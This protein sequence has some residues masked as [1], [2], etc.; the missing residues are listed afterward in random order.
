MIY[1]GWKGKS[2]RERNEPNFAK[3][4]VGLFSSRN[5]RTIPN[6]YIDLHRSISTLHK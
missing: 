3:F 1:V 6:L 4:E 5:E 2:E